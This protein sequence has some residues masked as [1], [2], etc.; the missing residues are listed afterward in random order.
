MHGL[1]FEKGSPNWAKGL[2]PFGPHD[3]RAQNNCINRIKQKNNS[4]KEI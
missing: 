2:G 4:S 3:F 1:I